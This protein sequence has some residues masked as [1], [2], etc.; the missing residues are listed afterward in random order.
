M[1]PAPPSTRRRARGVTAA[2][3]AACL[4]TLVALATGCGSDTVAAEDV[5]TVVTA[6]SL[7]PGQAI[8]VAAGDTVLSV[9]GRVGVPLSLDLPTLERFGQVAYDVTDPFTKK[10]EHYSGVLASRVLDAAEADPKAATARAHALDDFSVNVKT[11]DLRAYPVLVVT[12]MNGKRITEKQGGPLKLI[13]PYQAYDLD[14]NVYDHQWVWSLDS[15]T[16]R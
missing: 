13:F 9:K 3:L 14:H 1:H 11:A 5:Y 7:G 8:P 15:L 4:A 6:P 2:L 10:V 16:L 12:K